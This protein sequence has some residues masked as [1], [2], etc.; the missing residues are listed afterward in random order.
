MMSKSFIISCTLLMIVCSGCE[1]DKIEIIMPPETTIG[2]HTFGCYVNNYLFVHPTFK[3]L[4][5]PGTLI[6]RYF[7]DD[8]LLIINAQD[9]N[10]RQIVISDSIAEV[11]KTH[12][13][14]SAQ[15]MDEKKNVFNT[16]DELFAEIHLTEL[17]TV[18]LFVSGRFS[19]KAKHIKSD[20]IITVTDG[21]FDVRLFEYWY[22]AMNK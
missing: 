19:F 10:M 1:K 8:N 5:G 9:Y 12:R 11:G 20:S 14:I 3:G 15:Y 13:V 4:A 18:N 7:P 6:A 17:D 2:A 16:N 21:R 22:R